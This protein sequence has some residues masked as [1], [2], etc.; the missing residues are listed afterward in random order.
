[1]TTPKSRPSPESVL[2]TRHGYDTWAAHYDAEDN[3]LV[4]VEAQIAPALMPSLKGSRLPRCVRTCVDLSLSPFS[5]Y[6]E[7]A[8]FFVSLRTSPAR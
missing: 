1:M 7:A 5:L 4:L 8:T 2:S 3:P 6:L